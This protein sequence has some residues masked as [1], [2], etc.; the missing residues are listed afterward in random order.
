MFKQQLKETKLLSTR[1]KQKSPG[2]GKEYGMR[3]QS[4][5]WVGQEWK[6]HRTKDLGAAD[7][8]SDTPV[9]KGIKEVENSVPWSPFWCSAVAQQANCSRQ[10]HPAGK[11]GED[12]RRGVDH[13]VPS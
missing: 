13:T 12:S 10:R 9:F 4:G 6:K 11:E 7:V 1:I 5:G 8:T 3:G 2:H